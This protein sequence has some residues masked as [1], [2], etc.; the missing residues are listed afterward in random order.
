MTEPEFEPGITVSIPDK[1][2]GCAVQHAL[3]RAISRLSRDK[4]GVLRTA[5]MLVGETGESVDGMIDRAFDEAPPEV[6]EDV[7][8]T[9]RVNVG[10][11]LAEIDGNI[12]AAAQYMADSQ[13]ACKGVLRMRATRDSV[14]Y[15]VSVC[16]SRLVYE[17]HDPEISHPVFIRSE[18]TD[19]QA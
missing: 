9:L 10:D 16:T 2:R 7:K 5:G 12:E 3:A 13:Q 6:T 1:C 4:D 19:Q 17:N 8:R 14:T 11:R 15:T 18:P